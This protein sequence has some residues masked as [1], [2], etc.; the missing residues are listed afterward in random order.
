VVA[1]IWV[2]LLAIA[3]L[4]APAGSADGGLEL[5]V[6]QANGVCSDARAREEVTQTTPWCA[7]AAAAAGA[8]AGD[9]VWIAPG[10]YLGGVRP[11]ASGTADAPIRFLAATDGVTLDANGDTV[12]LKLIGVSHIAFSDITIT[13]AASQGVYLD[14][15]S[16]VSLA[17]LTVTANGGHGVQLR[18]SGVAIS[19]STISANGIAG[20]Q[21][22]AGSTANRYTRNTIAGNGHDGYPYS[23]DGIQLNGAGAVV[24]GNTVTENGDPGPYEH[25]IYAASAA[26]D[27]VIESN[28]LELNAGS[29]VKAAGANGTVRYNRISDGRLGLVLSD[30]ATSVTAYYNVIAGR[31][32]H[33]VFLTTDRSPARARLWN[34]TIVQQR[35]LTSSGEASAVF[36]NSAASVDIRNNL[37]CYTGDDNLGVALWVNDASLLG[38]LLSNRNWFCSRDPRKRHLA[39]NGSRTTLPAW[40]SKTGQDTGSIASAPPTFDAQWRVSSSNLGRG[41]GD[42]LGLERDFAG[43]PV[44]AGTN[45][46]IG[47]FQ[48][49]G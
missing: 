17:R 5:W 48:A 38:S 2:A 8:R 16:D 10:R 40:R 34:N 42:S 30:N 19:D 36:V 12:G 43:N 39:W 29:N 46:D 4:V 18:A 24:S 20:I 44:P 47:A 31:F 23:G 32:Q 25:G 33:A 45:P 49:S 27:Y 41:R 26:S 37:I 13:R 9:T 6:D 35:R 15:A 21:E 1:R 3:L 14:S 28:V 7:I 22:R 11:A